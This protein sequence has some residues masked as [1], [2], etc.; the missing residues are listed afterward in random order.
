MVPACV[1]PR[2]SIAV[3]ELVVVCLS[4]DPR[5]RLETTIPLHDIRSGPYIKAWTVLV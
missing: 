5:L 2:G 4:R 1:C 3:D